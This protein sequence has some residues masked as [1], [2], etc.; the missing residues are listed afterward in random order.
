MKIL[1]AIIHVLLLILFS[2]L[3]QRRT[4]QRLK[5]Y[6]WS[7]L[8][9]KIAAGISIGLIYSYYYEVGDTFLYFEDGKVLA[10]L[11]RKDLSVFLN[12]L[13]TDHP[14]SPVSS[15]L[16]LA[17]PRALFFVKFVS[18]IN[19]I[20]FDNYW[21]GACYFSLASFLGSWYL[22]T[23]L[24]FYFPQQTLP[25]FISF[26]FF[27]SVVLWTGGLIKESLAAAALFYLTA[28]FLV[29]WFEKRLDAISTIASLL[30]L[31]VLWGLKYYYAAIFIPVAVTCMLYRFLFVP[32]IN[33]KHTVSQ[34]ALWVSIFLIPLILVSFTHPNFYLD[35]FLE[36]IVSNNQ[37]YNQFSQPEDIIHFHGLEPTVGSLLVNSP[38]AFVAGLYRPFIWETGN[39]VQTIAAV[40]NFFL[41]VISLFALKNIFTLPSA[42][43]RILILALLVYVFLLCVFITLSTPNFGTLSR[44]RVGYL[45]YFLFLILSDN[46]ITRFLERTFPVLVRWP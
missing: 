40:E 13:V 3:L 41:I 18:V 12:F 34:I 16:H 29:A 27:P 37:V 19:L 24:Q 45:P 31:W 11:G 39:A 10:E 20:T 14:S 6:L 15:Q 32:F 36:V 23:K 38:K 7:G 42:G 17:D 26:L 9:V 22:F 33:P 5:K 28:V 46:P 25:A 8:F 43:H 1:I 4:E 2:W 35:R 44:Y 30:A 21:L